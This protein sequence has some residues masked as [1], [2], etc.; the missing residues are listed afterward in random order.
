MNI[1]L[2]RPPSPELLDDRIDPPTGLLYLGTALKHSGHDVTIL[3]FAGGQHHDIPSADIYGM[4]LFTSSYPDAITLRDKI[5][6]ISQSPIMVGGPHASALPEETA[7]DFDYVI[8]G[9]AEVTLPSLIEEMATD[10]EHSDNIINCIAPQD[11][12]KLPYNDY[13]LV[14]INSYDRVTAGE[15]TVSILSGRGCPWKCIYCHTAALGDKVR[16]RSP[17]HVMGELYQ[18]DEEYDVAAL[19]FIDDNFLMNRRF[20]REIAPMLEA[21]GKP[22]RVYCRAQ[23]LTE[24]T[25]PLLA[26]SG[27]KMVGCGVESGSQKMHEIMGTGKSV[28]KMTKGITLA[29]EQG[30]EIRAGI[31]VGFPGETW[32]TVKESVKNLKKMPIDSYNLFNFIPLPGTDPF[33]HPEMYGITEISDDW[34]DFF[35]LYGENEATY[36][37][38]HENMDRETLAE[39]R[40]YMIEELDEVFK[41]SL[42]DSEFK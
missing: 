26:E 42:M 31:I 27:C 24:G 2:I 29:K 7:K 32:K 16:M 4:T 13:S 23:D 22:Y 15:T 28:E 34:K 19:R 1:C 39:M 14:D 10:Q 40:A 5:R 33:I 21:F 12:S 38:S 20:L 9:E 3:D 36:P 6:Q 11:L 25:V 41:P 30:I 37:F 35:M 17:E 8:V 18:L